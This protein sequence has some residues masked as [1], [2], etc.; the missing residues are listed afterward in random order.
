MGM[1]PSGERVVNVVGLAGL[2]LIALFLVGCLTLI[3]DFLRYMR[4]KN[5]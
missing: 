3:P 4:I 5:M 1:G 2:A